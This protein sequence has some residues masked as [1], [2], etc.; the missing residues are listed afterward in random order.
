[1]GDFDLNELRVALDDSV[2]E[3]LLKTV[4]LKGMCDVIKSGLVNN[5]ITMVG[6]GIST[7]AGIP[8][9]RS[10]KSGLYD[11]LEEYN[12]PYPTAVFSIDFFEENPD[13]FYEVARRIYRPYAKP[14]LAHYFC[15]L[16]HEKNL[17]LRH[18]TQVTSGQLL[19]CVSQNVDSLERLA[20]LPD[21]KIIEAHGSFN[22][23]HCMKCAKSFDFEFM[24][25]RIMNSE[26]PK[27]DAPDCDGVIK[28]GMRN[29]IFF[30]E[31]LP[32]KFYSAIVKDFPA[33]DLLIIMGTSLSVTPFCLLVNRV[34]SNVP[35]LYLNREASPLGFDGIPWD[36][37]ENK[38]DVFV[39]GDADDSVLRLSDLLG[40]KEE[41]IQMKR[42][43]DAELDE[44]F[45]KQSN[46]SPVKAAQPTPTSK[47]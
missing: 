39:A 28:P 41:L 22:T 30:G 43:K 40:W 42:K 24:R 44:L 2:G 18:L 25:V 26:V 10:P 12:L 33:C 4:D 37:P 9:F 19:I 38:R 8:D 34:R 3:H 31:A 46:K 15:R 21:D 32:E 20:G 45:A 16:L 17:L 5:I 6:A 36:A 7:A 35:R 11:N 27:C 13:P 47:E 23:G 14:T 29:I 1:M